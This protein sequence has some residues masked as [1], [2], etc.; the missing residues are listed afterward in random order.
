MFDQL[1]QL[2]GLMGQAGQISQRMQELQASLAEKT[3]EADAGGGAVRVTATGTLE[4]RQVRVDP[5]MIQAFLGEGDEA[6]RTMVEELISS[7]TNAALEK[8]K[9]LAQQELMKSA[10][11]L[12]IPGLEKFFGGGQG[13]PSGQSGSTA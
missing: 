3:V 7:A 5:V 4:I 12:N 6:D 13:G 11:N 2:G 8:A 9:Q 10:G 1:R